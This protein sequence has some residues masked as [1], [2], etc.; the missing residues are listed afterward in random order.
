MVN[1]FDFTATELLF[2]RF[3]IVCGITKLGVMPVILLWTGIPI[4]LVGGG[5]I[6]YRVIG[7]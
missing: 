1:N 4:L 3:V 2:S 7:G 6:V 5:Y